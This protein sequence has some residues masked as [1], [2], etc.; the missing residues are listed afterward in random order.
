MKTFRQFLEAAGDPIKP[1]Q[2]ISL[3]D[4]EVQRNLR[5]AMI[6]APPKPTKPVDRVGKFVGRMIR[7]TLLSP[8]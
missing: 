8:Q 5:N 4:P 1:A 3:N 2:V 6:Q 7:N